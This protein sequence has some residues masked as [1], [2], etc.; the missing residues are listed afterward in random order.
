M[1]NGSEIPYTVAIL[2]KNWL[3]EN[4]VQKV[5]RSEKNSSIAYFLASKAKYLAVSA[6]SD[7]ILLAMPS[8]TSYCS[9]AVFMKLCI[10]SQEMCNC[11]DRCLPT[12][13]VRIYFTTRTYFTLLVLMLN[14][15]ARRTQYS[16]IIWC[17]LWY[18]KLICDAVVCK[19][20][21]MTGTNWSLGSAILSFSAFLTSVSSC[22]RALPIARR[23]FWQFSSDTNKPN[24]CQFYR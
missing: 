16:V 19:D 22:L 11:Y 5:F 7:D 20:I 3:T 21:D 1:Q 14:F 12:C 24:S 6:K 18:A 8:S 9:L 2:H 13:Y 17:R 23:F 10:G 15:Y 4:C